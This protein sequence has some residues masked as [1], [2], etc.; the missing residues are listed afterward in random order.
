MKPFLKSIVTRL[1]FAHPL[2]HS[3]CTNFVDVNDQCLLAL[4]QPCMSVLHLDPACLRGDFYARSYFVGVREASVPLQMH[5]KCHS[6]GMFGTDF[7]SRKQ[8]CM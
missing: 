6:I 7:G 4:R 5:L 8:A 2:H 3:A 1:R